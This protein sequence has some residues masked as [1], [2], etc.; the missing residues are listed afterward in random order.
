MTHAK[1]LLYHSIYDKDSLPGCT[2]FA[3][4]K[5]AVQ[6]YCEAMRAELA[7]TG[8]SV[9]VA[10]PGFIRTKFESAVGIDAS[11]RGRSVARKAKGKL[12]K[13]ELVL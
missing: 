6:G 5:F 12:R 11:P 13:F 1:L 10:S 2:S 4:S 3:A 8:V 9:H 7:K